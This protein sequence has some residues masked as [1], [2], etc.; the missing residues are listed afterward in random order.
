LGR[1]GA[2]LQN[3]APRMPPSAEPT[4]RVFFALVPPPP[5]RDELG[6]LAQSV[7]RRAHGRAVLASNLHVTL[8]FIGAWPVSRLA[9]WMDVGARCAGDAMYVSLDRLGGFRRAGVAWIGSRT[10]PPPL[11]D[12]AAALNAA[13]VAANVAVDMRAFAPHLTLARRCRGPF[14]DEPIRPY[15]WRVDAIALMQSHT[16]PAGVR[17]VEAGHWPLR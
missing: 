4:A 1:C 8:A 7:A 13:L 6:M 5:L 9:H 16:E 15:G 2:V 14:P 11:Q 12:L 10:I 3:A 17:Y